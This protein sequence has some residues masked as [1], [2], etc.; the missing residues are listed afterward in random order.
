MPC[1]ISNGKFRI[2]KPEDSE[3]CNLRFRPSRG[4]RPVD[5]AAEG[6]RLALCLRF[7]LRNPG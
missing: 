2:E 1:E 7:Q 3:I 5:F 6:L 4:E